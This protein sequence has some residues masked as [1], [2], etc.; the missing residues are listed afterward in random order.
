[1]PPTIIED[2][3]AQFYLDLLKSQ[4]M[5]T[6]F[7]NLG[8][9][10]NRFG[11]ML[12]K[13][14]DYPSLYEV[15]RT[16]NKPSSYQDFK[17]QL[18]AVVEPASTKLLT[19]RESNWNNNNESTVGIFNDI[20][21]PNQRYFYMFRTIDNHD[22]LS[23]PSQV[24][25]VEII[26]EGGAIYPVIETFDFDTEKNASSNKPGKRFI[27]IVP[28]Y[29]QYAFNEKE[30]SIAKPSAAQM[31]DAQ[32]RRFFERREPGCPGNSN[33]KSDLF[34][35]LTEKDIS[36]GLSEKRIWGKKFKIRL[37]SKKSGKKVDL[38]IDFKYS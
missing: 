18:L 22:H 7:I 1:M 24:Y 19:E 26:D 20:I 16:T 23:N 21:I 14:D 32:R 9:R 12:F 3:D 10:E 33:V 13:S 34:S 31:N 15:Y 38:N 29:S 6:P 25:S 37:I 36:L 17:G 30:S 11:N 27:Q 35:L 2:A 5:F 8:G 4:N 28:T